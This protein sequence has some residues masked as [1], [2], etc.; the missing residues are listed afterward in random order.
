MSSN[1]TLDTFNLPGVAL[2]RGV[3]GLSGPSV[4]SIVVGCWLPISWRSACLKLSNISQQ[5]NYLGKLCFEQ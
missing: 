2:S 5:R 3:A 4:A 1:V